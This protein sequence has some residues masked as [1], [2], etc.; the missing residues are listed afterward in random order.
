MDDGFPT[1]A[2]EEAGLTNQT[3]KNRIFVQSCAQASWSRFL[4][5]TPRNMS[6]ELPVHDISN[7]SELVAHFDSD[8]ERIW[9]GENGV[10]ILGTPLGSNSYVASYLRGRGSS[11]TSSSASSRT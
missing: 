11:I 7:D 3:V 1:L 6:T 10:N 5:M 8:R 9:V 4:D 2:W